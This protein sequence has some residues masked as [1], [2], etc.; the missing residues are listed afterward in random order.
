MRRTTCIS[1]AL[2]LMTCAAYSQKLSDQFKLDSTS[3]QTETVE[4]KEVPTSF[5]NR[6]AVAVNISTLGGGLEVAR[7]ITP[8]L[9][10]RLRGNMFSL[11]DYRVDLELGGEPVHINA[12]TQF[13]EMDLVAEYLPFKKSSFKLV[14]G[15]GYFMKAEANALA[16][17]DGEIEYGDLTMTSDEIGTIDF[18]VDYS[19]LS[20]YLGLG[21]GRAVPKKRVGFGVEL[22]SFYLAKPKVTIIATKM[23]SPT[24]EEAQT[25]Q[26][27]ISDYRWFPFVNFRLAVRI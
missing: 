11:E 27:N 23:L 14:G 22:G 9:N 17:Y 26:E 1:L 18:M 13:M 19:G 25:L 6:F 8:H 10:L 4:P 2:F 3:T 5:Y 24:S 12:S 16:V 20:P 15:V 7:N 21:F